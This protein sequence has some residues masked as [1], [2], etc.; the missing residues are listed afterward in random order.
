MT[1]A[2]VIGLQQRN[3]DAFILEISFGLGEVQRRVVCGCVP[4]QR[5]SVTTSIILLQS[6]ANQLVRKVILSL[7]IAVARQL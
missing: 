3:F 7:A 4:T 2:R 5:L 1:Y 6:E